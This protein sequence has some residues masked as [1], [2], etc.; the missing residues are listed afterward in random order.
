MHVPRPRAP[1]TCVTH[2]RLVHVTRHTTRARYA[3]VNRRTNS[4]WWTV[5]L[6]KR[7]ELVRVR[8]RRWRRT[9][10]RGPELYRPWSTADLYAIVKNDERRHRRG[11][12]ARQRAHHLLHAPRYLQATTCPV[13][14]VEYLHIHYIPRALLNRHIR[15]EIDRDRS[16]ERSTR[17]RV[18]SRLRRTEFALAVIHY[19]NWN[20]ALAQLTRVP[21]IEIFHFAC[22]LYYSLYGPRRERAEC[23]WLYITTERLGNITRLPPPPLPLSAV[24]ER[25]CHINSYYTIT[26]IRRYQL[27]VLMP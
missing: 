12:Q 26:V 9:E 17:V 3:R 7:E 1:R 4:R 22:E 11:R 23:I 10:G 24:I 15:I 20:A 25:H 13:H 2:V 5:R 18:R 21:A 27:P 19:D 16:Q 6:W 8:R 14:P